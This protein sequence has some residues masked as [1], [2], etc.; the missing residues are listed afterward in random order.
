MTPRYSQ[1]RWFCR[2]LPVL[3]RQRQRVCPV[4][5]GRRA[6]SHCDGE[7]IAGRSDGHA[8]AEHHLLAVAVQH[9]VVWVPGQR[10]S[11]RDVYF[12]LGFPAYT[13]TNQNRLLLGWMLVFSFF[14]MS[15]G[16]NLHK[17]N[18][19]AINPALPNSFLVFTF[20]DLL[21]LCG[22]NQSGLATTMIQQPACPERGCGT[23]EVIIRA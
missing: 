8:S 7:D 2:Y 15:L 1:H 23:S 14:H 10:Q 19:Y 13:K 20:T 17:S 3:G 9:A 6:N 4:G 12:F 16:Q 11:E 21:G 18:K 22:N 5:T